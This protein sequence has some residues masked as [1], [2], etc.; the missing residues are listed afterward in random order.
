MNFPKLPVP[1]RHI[2]MLQL[3]EPRD[4]CPWCIPEAVVRKRVDI[5]RTGDHKILKKL[6]R[7]IV[8]KNPFDQFVLNLDNCMKKLALLTDNFIKNA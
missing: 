3:V 7:T 2:R 8:K 1:K 6:F 5:V 4:S